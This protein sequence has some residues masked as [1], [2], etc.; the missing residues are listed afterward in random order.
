M[1]EMILEKKPQGTHRQVMDGRSDYVG[2]VS[3]DRAIDVD[4]HTLGVLQ[5]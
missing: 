5:Y 3:L 1:L 4:N 2:E